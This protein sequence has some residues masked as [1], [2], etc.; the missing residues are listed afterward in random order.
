MPSSRSNAAWRNGNFEIVRL[1]GDPAPGFDCGRREQNDYLYQLARRDQQLLLSV[2]RLCFVEKVLAAYFTTTVDAVELGSRE[3]D[4]GV[5][6]RMLPA[7][8]LAQ[9]GVD[10]RFAGTGLG[11]F[12]LGYTIEN[13]RLVRTIVGVRYVTLDAKP[14]LEAWYGGY[15]FVRNKVVQKRRAEARPDDD[16][17]PVSMRFDLLR[18]SPS[19]EPAR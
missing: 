16:Y 14:D 17:L 19:R 2:T 6:Y 8:K 12:L 7:L 3:K 4:P 13:A 15:G 5:H 9:L 10:R 11:R 18:P 1:D